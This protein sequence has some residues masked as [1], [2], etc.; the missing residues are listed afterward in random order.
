VRSNYRE[1]W[2]TPISEY[3]LEDITLQKY[4]TDMLFNQQDSYGNPV[5]NNF[6]IIDNQEDPFVQWTYSCVYDFLA[7]F[8]TTDKKVELHRAWVS[9]QKPLE[10]VPVHSHAP[11]DV[12]AVYY[13]NTIPEH[14]ELL[15]YDPR[16]A[17]R[18]NEV[19]IEKNGI[20]L[21][22]GARNIFIK[23][24]PYKMVLFPG[25]LLHSVNTNLTN[26][27]RFSL[28]MNFKLLR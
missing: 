18:F 15:V 13:I 28:A 25:Y 7:K 14:P 9:S 23:P 24:E 1:I 22:D 11:V 3:I 19:V 4:I 21:D 26:V 6:N 10:S 27:P 2:S 20:V 12:V 17:H 16:P 5:G 8:Y